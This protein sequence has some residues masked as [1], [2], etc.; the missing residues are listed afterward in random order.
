MYFKFNTDFT[1]QKYSIDDYTTYLWG[2]NIFEAG[3]GVDFL[4]TIINF[5]FNIDPELRAFFSSNPQF[6]A[7]LNDLKDTRDD[8]RYHA[9]VQNNFSINNKLF[10]QPGLR[11][12]YYDILQKAY[13]APRISMSYALDNLTTLR[14]VWGIYYQSPGYEKLRDENV[15]YDLSDIYARELKAEQAVHYIL[16][17]ERWLNA[18]WSVKLEGYY[19][20]FNNLI[21]QKIVPGSRYLTSPIPGKDPRYPDGWTQ[22]VT[23]TGDSITQIP[24]N[25]ADGNAYGVEIFLARKNL[26]PGERFS[27]WISYAYAVANRNEDELTLP[28]RFDQRHTVNIV[29]NY[30]LTGWLDVGLRW[31]YGSGF[32]ISSPSGVKPRIVLVD[33]NADGIPETPE[34]ATR[35]PYF[36]G[37]GEVIYDVDYGSQRLNARKPAYHRLDVR[38]TAVTNFWNLDW[39][40]YLD[41]INAYNRANI[42][43]YDYYV[44]NDLTLGRDTNTMFPIIP[45]LG[46]SVKF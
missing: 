25:N 23:V 30:Q 39:S 43:G 13:A 44:N 19:K 10:F 3:A 9:F 40:F 33:K 29:L 11:F 28:F 7:V 31:Q 5:Q 12:D 1:F 21:V 14:A 24:V 41:V 17:I 4:R 20:D 45:T 15:L 32:P 38:I 35:T 34:I 37:T 42:V 2:D 18:E 6:R 16:G 36:G 22:P 26:A 27:G 46:F 8:K